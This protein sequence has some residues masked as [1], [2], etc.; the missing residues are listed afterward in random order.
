[1][2]TGVAVGQSRWWRWWK[3]FSA[4]FAAGTHHWKGSQK[5]GCKDA[6]CRKERVD[7]A[8]E[9]SAVQCNAVKSKEEGGQEER[10]M[11]RRRKEVMEGA[12]IASSSGSGSGSGSGTKEDERP[13][14]EAKGKK[15]DDVGVR[16]LG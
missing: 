3:S 12:Q 8:E 10:R 11:R 14:Q 2:G 15:M 7:C 9:C 16:S 5:L 1:M 13:G 4:E 6:Q